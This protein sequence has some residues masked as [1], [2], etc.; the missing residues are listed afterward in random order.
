M[1]AVSFHNVAHTY[2]TAPVLSGIEFEIKQNEFL[3]II[4]RSGSGKSTLLQMVNGLVIPSAGQL[5]LFGRKIDY[6]KINQ[7]RLD[8][9]YLVQGAALFPHMN[10][11]D[12]ISILAR[13]KGVPPAATDD[14]IHKLLQ[15]VDLDPA[16]L[17]KYPY[18][19]SGGEQQRVGI[20]RAMMLNPKIFL[21]DEPFAALDPATKGEIHREL[22]TLQQEEPRTIIMVTHDL[23][24]A[25][26]LADRLLILERGVV[27]QLDRVADVLRQPANLFVAEFIKE[28]TGD[29]HV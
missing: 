11:R 23:R 7:I 9:G 27:Q 10:I 6:L 22:L 19:L 16:Y 4:G 21:L 24:E 2:D 13:I 1:N 28:Q 3:V 15:M 17:S 12:N 29:V 8:I 18:Q 25:V 14:R 20:C 26:K 5:K